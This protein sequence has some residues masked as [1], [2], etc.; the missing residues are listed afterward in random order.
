MDNQ[1]WNI[2]STIWGKKQLN[3]L[4]RI[5]CDFLHNNLFNN[6][7]STDLSAN[8]ILKT[9][10]FDES[11]GRGMYDSIT[12]KNREMYGSDISNIIVKKARQKYPDI[13]GIIADIRTLPFTDEIFDV[14]VSNSTL[15]HFDTT[16]KIQDSLRE[17]N[18]VLKKG[19]QLIITLDNPTNPLVFIRNA[20]PKNLLYRLGL[21]PYYNGVTL[22]RRYFEK[23]L[24]QADFDIR[25][26]GFLMH[27]PRII[28]IWISFV[29]EKYATE[30]FRKLF[31]KFLLSFETLA[32]LP[33]DRFTGHF[34]TVHAVKGNK[35]KKDSLSVPGSTPSSVTLA[36]N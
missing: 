30:K 12:S 8:R 27:C 24:I 4:W 18:R 5:Y 28:A 9:D 11:I 35:L 36:K 6:Y 13:H 17:L 26:T 23:A 14:I 32:K 16:D 3:S 29:M 31:V 21:V 22:N 7:L 33:T 25:K 2:V 34:I 1:Y 19:G 10:L 15:D 20:L